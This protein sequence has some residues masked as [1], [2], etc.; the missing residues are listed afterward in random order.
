[1][2]IPVI[3]VSVCVGCGDCAL[4]CPD[5]AIAIIDKKARID[6]HGCT[7]CGVCDNVCR[8]GA[9]EIK[10]PEMPQTLV[11]GVQLTTLKAEVKQLKRDL[12]EL[13]KEMRR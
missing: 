8:V 10:T 12:K 1:M 3:D 13:R 11:E 2:W 4:A 6:Y 5:N 9:L 7:C